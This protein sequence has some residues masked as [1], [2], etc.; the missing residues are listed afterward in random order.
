[1]QPDVICLPWGVALAP[2]S[3]TLERGFASKRSVKAASAI[4][5]R[6]SW[7]AVA[8]GCL[9]SAM[10]ALCQATNEAASSAMISPKSENKADGSIE[11][12]KPSITE[13][14]GDNSIA[15]DPATLLPDLPPLP[16]QKATLVGG[17]VDRIDLVRDQITVRLFGGGKESFLFDTRTQVFRGSK[18][19]TVA[20]LHEGERIYLD[21]ILDGSNQFARTMRLSAAHATG[22]SQGVVVKFRSNRSALVLR[23][24][25]SPN[26]VEVRL[27]PSTRV[28]EAG[29]SVPI[30]A[31]VPGSLISLSFNSVAGAGNTA[32]EI[33]ILAQP[34][35]QYKFSGRVVHLDLRTGLL[36]LNSSTDRKTY[37]IYLASGMNPDEKLRPGANVTVFADFDG[38]RYVVRNIRFSSE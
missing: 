21:T 7:G 26:S 15:V 23:D 13:D 24:A 12:R 5:M 10:P 35:T 1:M 4:C 17:T 30:Y 6:F 25:L 28:S 36:V 22:T 16:K 38:E 31:I 18:P 32:T 3:T 20:D 9:L 37:E 19:G 29:R 33:A 8:L 34:G 14:S 11:P 2:I 27:S